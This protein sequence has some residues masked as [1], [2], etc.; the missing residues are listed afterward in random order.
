MRQEMYTVIDYKEV[1]AL[2]GEFLGK[3]DYE[4]FV[5]DMGDN[6]GEWRNDTEH[7][8][9]IEPPEEWVH[10]NH[11]NE[12]TEVLKRGKPKWN[13]ELASV[14]NELGARGKLP[15]GNLLITI[16]W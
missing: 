3:P 9:V 1:S 10:P 5:P 2:V 6:N 7:A 11:E 15:L 12:L 8:F 14:L 4:E 13:F 16:C